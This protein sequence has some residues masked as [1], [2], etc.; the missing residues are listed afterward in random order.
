MTQPTMDDALR[1]GLFVAPLQKPPTKGTEYGVFR[2][3]QDAPRGR[4]YLGK[5]GSLSAALRLVELETTVLR[6]HAQEVESI[7]PKL[8][9]VK[10]AS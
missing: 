5:R 3:H 6:V 8:M 7:K 2:M 10:E 4:E 1:L 9:L